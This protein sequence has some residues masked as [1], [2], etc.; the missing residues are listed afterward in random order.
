ML[1]ETT[2]EGESYKNLLLFE[3]PTV[4]HQYTD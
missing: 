3:E 4:C 2:L 1:Q